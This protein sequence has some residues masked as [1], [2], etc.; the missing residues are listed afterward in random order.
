[1]TEILL[2]INKINMKSYALEES[3]LATF[4][5]CSLDMS[6]LSQILVVISTK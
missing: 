5:A 1:M 2:I 3:N 4:E 6:V